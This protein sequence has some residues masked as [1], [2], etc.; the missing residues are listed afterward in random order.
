MKREELVQKLNEYERKLE[1]LAWGIQTHED[2]MKFI[3][4][5]K[6]VDAYRKELKELDKETIK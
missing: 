2:F 6:Q 4:C 1:D 5:S 3:E